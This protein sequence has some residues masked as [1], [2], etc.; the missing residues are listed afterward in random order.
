MSDIRL[1]MVNG[2]GP[3]GPTYDHIMQTSFC[4]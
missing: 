3:S 1:A 4:R 2:T